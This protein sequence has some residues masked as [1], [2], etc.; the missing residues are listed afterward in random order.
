MLVRSDT[1]ADAQQGATKSSN[2]RQWCGVRAG[3][4][5]V[6]ALI[7][8]EAKILSRRLR[9]GVFLSKRFCRALFA[10]QN[11]APAHV[12]IGAKCNPAAHGARRS[13]K[14]VAWGGA[15]G[16]RHRARAFSVDHA[17][18]PVSSLLAAAVVDL[19]DAR[20]MGTALGPG[21]LA[22]RDLS[23]GSG[24]REIP[25]DGRQDRPQMIQPVASDGDIVVG[26]DTITSRFDPRH[27]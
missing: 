7:S 20:L 5:R 1:P 26:K 4:V 11:A 27:R 3:R 15:F 24:S 21:P 22:A 14:A 19:P 10:L 16:D 9:D 18:T 12:D 13:P 2:A 6:D 17:D 8:A 25:P 23:A